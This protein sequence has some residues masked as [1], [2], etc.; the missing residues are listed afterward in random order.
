MDHP[1][2]SVTPPA[3]RGVAL[4]RPD[5]SHR[6][7]LLT[8]LAVSA[9][10]HLVGLVIYPRLMHLEVGG[11]APF[12]IPT[13]VVQPIEGMTVIEVVEVSEAEST[14]RPAE[15]EQVTEIQGP[16]VRPG[17]PDLG[18]PAEVG[19]V[20]PGPTAAERLRPRA[21]DPRL[22]AP[23]DAALNELTVEQRLQLELA[24]RI[25]AWQD[26]LSMAAAAEGALTDWTRTDS[27][28]RKWGISEGKLHLGDVTLPLPFSFGMAVGR[29]D[30]F[31]RNA[32]I[33]D[34][35]ER[36]K[37]T[38]ERRD[39]WKE[40]AQAIRERRDRERAQT[41]PDTSGVRR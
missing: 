9:V 6:R 11:P 20:A 29:R 30:E 31:R 22:W 17:L 1:A 38:G 7:A 15:P 39:S 21:G 18:N 19:I 13:N 28:G 36:G 33:W 16:A 26:S 35:I 24:W 27:Q 25:A 40:R 3:D 37:A 34:E 8:G 2:G 5:A 14:D 23:L 10:V 32:W 4:R 12:R 41:K